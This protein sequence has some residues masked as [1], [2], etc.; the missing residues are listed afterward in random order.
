[1]TKISYEPPSTNRG[2]QTTTPQQNQG[3][4]ETNFLKEKQRICVDWCQFTIIDKFGY[5]AYDYFYNLFGIRKED[6]LL[7]CKG[8][9]CY[10]YTYSYKNIKIF[11]SDNPEYG[12]HVYLTGQACR[13]FEDITYRQSTGVLTFNKHTSWL[14]LFEKA[15][16]YDANFTRLD[17]AI[18]DFSGEYFT[19]DDLMQCIENKEVKTRF[20]DVTDF[21]KIII[22]DC[23][24]NGR[25][26]W[27]GSRASLIQIV[28]YDKLLE[29]QSQNYIVD[30][31]IKFWLRC[32]MRFRTDRANEIVD[33]YI[34]ETDDFSTV[35]KG[36][37]DYYVS[38][39]E[40]DASDKNRWR[41]K[42]KDFWN[43]YL[44]NVEKSRLTSIPIET[45]IVRKKAWIDNT[46]SRSEFAVLL[47]SLD[48]LSL[49]DKTSSY[50][51]EL[52]KSGYSKLEEK[53]LDMINEYRVQNNMSVIT[54]QEIED[55]IKD[56][57]SVILLSKNKSVENLRENF[58]EIVE[59]K[60]VENV[61]KAK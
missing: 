56:I 34:N 46:V 12:Y 18:D 54:M 20:R 60:E 11:A 37:L 27:F 14:S 32:E 15:K 10:S 49:D 25:T 1:M 51:Y 33:K 13:D 58:G 48:N 22:D 30:N 28:F 21:K 31:D 17:I 38:F 29:R 6:I 55:F 53:D 7:E 9:F 40:Y 36:V 23:K 45:S 47:S 42:R 5:S 2:V 50:F 59:T 26:L 43:R 61:N 8:L 24:I 39:L 4:L 35:I 52:L 57:K 16:R 3:I 44:D 41:W 19:L